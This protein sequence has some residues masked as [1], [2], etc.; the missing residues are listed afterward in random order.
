[1]IGFLRGDQGGAGKKEPAG[2]P[3]HCG[4][5]AVGSAALTV[6]AATAWLV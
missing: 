2:G 1:M 4:V 6:L 3:S 5:A